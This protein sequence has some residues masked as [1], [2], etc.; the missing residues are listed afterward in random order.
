MNSENEFQALVTRALRDSNVSHMRNVIEK[1]LLIYDILFCLD[2]LCI[3]D[4]IVF[5]GGSLLRFGHGGQRFSEELDF[6][7][8]KNFSVSRMDSLKLQIEQFVADRYGLPVD[9]KRPKTCKTNLSRSIA[10]T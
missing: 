4:S 10:G 8:G 9:I 2:N 6:V 1:E 7:S 5:Q 3:L